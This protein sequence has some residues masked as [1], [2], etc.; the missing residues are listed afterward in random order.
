MGR[1]SVGVPF[2]EEVV[3]GCRSRLCGRIGNVTDCS[4][5]RG[6]YGG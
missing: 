1:R 2:D 6:G 3:V 4:S 5:T